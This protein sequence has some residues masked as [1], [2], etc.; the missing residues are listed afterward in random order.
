M[1]FAG[2]LAFFGLAVVTMDV[3]GGVIAIGVMLRG[4]TVR[5]LLAFGGGY[6][7]II[8]AATLILQPLLA[9]LNRWLHPLLESNDAIGAVEIVVGLALAAFSVHQFRAAARPPL[10]HGR[11]ERRSTPTRLATA[12]LVLAGVGFSATALVDPGFAIAVGMASQEQHLALRVVLLVRGTSS[13]RHR[14]SP[15]S[16]RRCSAGTSSWSRGSWSSLGP[17]RR[18]LQTAFAVLLALA[19]LAV[20]GDGLFALLRGA[21]A[22][23]AP[24]APA[25]V[26]GSAEPLWDITVRASP[27]AAVR[28]HGEHLEPPWASVRGAAVR[29][30]SAWDWSSVNSAWQSRAISPTSGC[31]RVLWSSNRVATSWRAHRSRNSSLSFCRAVTSSP[32]P[33]S[34]GLRRCRPCA[35]RP[36]EHGSAEVGRRA[37]RG[38]GRRQDR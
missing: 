27:C 31:I 3:L 16:S 26:S 38:R 11:L 25:A 35:G 30:S 12:P 32:P 34:P 14:W 18:A 13:T 20:L 37:D 1:T 22:V 9:L 8:V 5:H 4:G 21:R 19:G 23:A 24:A 7:V 10:P 29:T 2:I 28:S 17:R 15:C 6:T 33:G 36:L